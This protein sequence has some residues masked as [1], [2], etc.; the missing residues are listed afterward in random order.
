LKPDI[1]PGRKDHFETVALALILK[2]LAAASEEIIPFLKINF[3][4]KKI[5]YHQIS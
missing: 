3:V 2:V 5:S 1:I 4:D